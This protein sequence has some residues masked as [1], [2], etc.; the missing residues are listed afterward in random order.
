MCSCTVVSL[1][2]PSGE[3]I[4]VQVAG[5]VD[6]S[7]TAV[8]RDA[9]ADSLARGPCALVVDLAAL[10]FCDVGGLRLL[11]ESGIGAAGQEIGYAVADVPAQVELAWSLLWPA[12]GL[13]TQ[14]PDAA[15][16]VAAAV[17]HPGGDD[18]AR[19][20]PSAAHG[21]QHRC[22]PVRTRRRSRW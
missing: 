16:G 10:T 13:P 15:A 11:V 19:W 9:L 3:V 7:T 5:E 22:P 20:A 8:L 21:N 2:S 4:V 12:T 6:L 17:A 14:F 18:R 1:A